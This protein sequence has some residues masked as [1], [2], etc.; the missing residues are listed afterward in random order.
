V[1][2]IVAKHRDDCSIFEASVT[3][4]DMVVVLAH[5]LRNHRRAESI[6]LFSSIGQAFPQ[7]YGLLHVQDD[8]AADFNAFRVFR[9]A[10]GAVQEF[11]DPFFS[12]RNPVIDDEYAGGD[13]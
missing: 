11:P 9:L 4:I 13:D 6:Q 5:G 10:R 12:P 3:S 1:K 2:Q 8:E 7:A